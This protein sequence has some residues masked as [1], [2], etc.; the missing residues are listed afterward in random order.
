MTPAKVLVVD[1]D[2]II[3]SMLETLL[4][5]HGCAI[6]TVSDGEKAI[7]L[8]ENSR[9]DL[10]L[11]D[12]EMGKTSGF[13]V[14]RKAKEVAPDTLVFMMTSCHQLEYAIT[15]FRCGA[16]GYLLKPFSSRCLFER[17]QKNG[18][19]FISR[20]RAIT[21]ESFSQENL[22]TAIQVLPSLD[23]QKLRYAELEMQYHSLP[24]I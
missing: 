5:N 22:Q 16:S 24:S 3:R 11:T 19:P 1:D 23:D 10:V 17:L 8:L 2:M 13:E 15:A 6:T 18:F 7:Q 12:L 4:N 14:I 20:K 9:F 21:A